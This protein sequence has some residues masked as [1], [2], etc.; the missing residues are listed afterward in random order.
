MRS[1]DI[2]NATGSEGGY[3]IAAGTQIEGDFMDIFFLVDSQFD[4]SG[5]ESNIEDFASVAGITFAA[6]QHLMGRFG[7]VQLSQGKAIVY[8]E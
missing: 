2:A 4:V 3:Y 5:T 7:K 8:N 1:V 6:G